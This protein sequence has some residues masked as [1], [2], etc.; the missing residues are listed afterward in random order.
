MSLY[1]R[2][3]RNFYI[4]FARLLFSTLAKVEVSGRENLP[5]PA[6]GPFIIVANHF[7]MFEVPMLAIVLPKVPT[8]FGAKELLANPVVRYGQAGFREEIIFVRRGVIDRTALKAANDS[9]KNKSWLAIFPEGGITELTVEMST[10]GE[11]TESLIGHNSRLPAVLYKAR[12]GAA[13]LAIQSGAKILPISFAG[14]ENLEQNLPR[15]R[16][17]PIQVNI[18]KPFGPFQMPIDLNGRSRRE[19]IN[20][21]GDEMMES[22][23]RLISAEHRGVYN[24]VE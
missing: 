7:S 16:R 17:T 12:P 10:R 11:T 21:F 18:G 4:G 20:Q 6:D 1:S 9:L 8:Y 23:A 15:L 5:D 2:F 24:Y 3:I 19:V 13:L 14:T 22:I